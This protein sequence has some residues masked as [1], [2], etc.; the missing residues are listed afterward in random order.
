[1]RVFFEYAYI[2]AGLQLKCRRDLHRQLYLTEVSE[3]R[4]LRI[5][6]NKLRQIK[7]TAINVK[8]INGTDKK[9]SKKSLSRVT[10]KTF[11]NVDTQIV[12]SPKS[13]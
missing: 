3:E 10:S 6:E 13:R 1:M 11:L 7:E 12:N 8:A 4:Q 9:S 2:G 5:G